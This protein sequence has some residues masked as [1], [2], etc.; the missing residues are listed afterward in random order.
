MIAIDTNLIIRLLTKDDAEQ[1]KTSLKLF[2]SENLFVPDTVVLES[3]WVL[4]VAYDFS[5]EDICDAFRKLF[6][7]P[8]VHINNAFAIA[9]AIE[10]HE[11]GMEFADASHLSLSQS[12]RSLKTF[13]TKFIKISKNLSK[14][15]VEK[16]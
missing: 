3:E 2:E 13:D 14:C 9:Q 12:C 4:R 1:H 7:L 11:K 8:N 5:P 15:I 16:P 10:W 6:G